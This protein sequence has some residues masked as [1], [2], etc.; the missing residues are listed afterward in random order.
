MQGQM[1]SVCICMLE[2]VDALLVAGD[3]AD[4]YRQRYERGIQFLKEAAERVPTFVGIGNHERT[5]GAFPERC[6]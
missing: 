1:N 4:R 3:T 6:S 2:G 5:F